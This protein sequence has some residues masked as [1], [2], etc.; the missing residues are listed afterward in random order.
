[1]YF[2]DKSN[3][4]EIRN[5]DLTPDDVLPSPESYKLDRDDCVKHQAVPSPASLCDVTQATLASA[6]S[7]L[8][9]KTID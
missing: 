9:A 8:H 6:F 3:V 2:S 4:P 7:A 1:M 5:N